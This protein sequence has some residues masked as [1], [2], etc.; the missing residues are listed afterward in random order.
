MYGDNYS[1]G[2]TLPTSDGRFEFEWDGRMLTRARR[3]SDYTVIDYKYDADGNRT[4]K[5]KLQML[6]A[7]YKGSL[8]IIIPTV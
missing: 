7:Q 3:L 6:T 2:S 8:N 5:R 1:V 4:E